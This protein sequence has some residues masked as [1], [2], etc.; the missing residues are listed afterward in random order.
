MN[1]NANPGIDRFS[2]AGGGFEA[3]GRSGFQGG[4]AKGGLAF[5]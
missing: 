4:V 3:P 2:I 5:P 1:K